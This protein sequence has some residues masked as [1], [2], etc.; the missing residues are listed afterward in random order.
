MKMKLLALLLTVG[1]I[2]LGTGV[3]AA[4]EK[5]DQT[6][7]TAEERAVLGDTAGTLLCVAID[8]FKP[9]DFK[10]PQACVDVCAGKKELTE[11]GPCAKEI[12]KLGKVIDEK[13]KEPKWPWIGHAKTVIAGACY[14]GCTAKTIWGGKGTCTVDSA[15]KAC[16]YI[17]C[18]ISPKKL[19]KCLT[20]TEPKDEQ[21]P[22]FEK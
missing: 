13:T 14:A 3:N 5:L 12:V 10:L 16:G 2:A 15:R 21:C 19:G 20:D 6:K 22:F 1:I 8:Q 11:M 17:C 9:A 4:G 18:N 7:M